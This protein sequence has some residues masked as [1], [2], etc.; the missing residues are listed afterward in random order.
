MADNLHKNTGILAVCTGN[1]CRSP[2][3][4]GILRT[5][6]KSCPDIKISSAG[7]HAINGNSA[8]EFAIIA[9]IENGIDISGHSARLLDD[10]IIDD[11]SIILCMEPIHIELVLS[12]NPS[13]YG[14]IFN[15]SAFSANTKMRRKIDDPYGSSLRSYRNCFMDIQGCIRNFVSEHYRIL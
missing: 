13:A 10:K 3:A 7:T 1:I 15:L 8:V 6:F 4:E 9:S 2:M 14:K 5:I 11:S 12:L